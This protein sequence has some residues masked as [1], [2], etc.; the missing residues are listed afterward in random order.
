MGRLRDYTAKY[1]HIHTQKSHNLVMGSIEGREPSLEY[2]PY[3]TTTMGMAEHLNAQLAETVGEDTITALIDSRAKNY[4]DTP[5]LGEFRPPKDCGSDAGT[6]RWRSYSF[7]QLSQG[8]SAL[9]EKL[10][11]SS[12][13]RP[14][15]KHP[16]SLKCVALL[17]QTSVEL[18][19][20]WLAFMRLG[21]AVLLLAPQLTAEQIVH[22]CQSVGAKHLFVDRKLYET[23][24]I[25]AKIHKANSS[26]FLLKPH[27]LYPRKLF[28][29]LPEAQVIFSPPDWLTSQ[30]TAYIHH[31]SGTSS[32]KP[33][34]I[35][36]SHAGA[37]C[38]LPQRPVPPE[39]RK[40]QFTTTPLYH[41]GIADLMRGMNSN[42]LTWIVPASVP[43]TTTY[44]AT[45][46]RLAS[47]TTGDPSMIPRYFSC[48]PFILNIMSESNVGLEWLKKM[49]MVGVG[50][51]P[52]DQSIGD[53]LV[54]LG[55]K[56]VSR[57]GS[58]EA[59]Y[60]LNSF[61][62]FEKEHD[63][64]YL[65]Y[66]TEVAHKKLSFVERNTD[67]L[68]D[69][70]EL[71]KYEL[72]VGPTWPNLSKRNC[73]DGSF[74][75]SDLFTPADAELKKWKYT[76]RNDALIVL[77]SGKKYDPVPIETSIRRHPLIERYVSDVCIFV[78][79]GKNM[80]GIIIVHQVPADR[81]EPFKEK[82]KQVI[83][84]VNSKT[85]GNG[86][87]RHAWISEDLIIYD[88]A[89]NLPRNVKG[90]VIRNRTEEKY[91]AKIKE[92]YQQYENRFAPQ[93]HSSSPPDNRRFL[94]ENAPKDED[95]RS[96]RLQ[97]L[98]EFV[99]AVVRGI[100]LEWNTGVGDNEPHRNSGMKIEKT[101]DKVAKGL[102]NDTDLFSFGIDSVMGVE[103][104]GRLM[105]VLNLDSN[106][107]GT[108]IVFEQRTIR[109]L[110]K[111]ILSVVL[112]DVED[113]GEK[114]TDEE[115]M[116]GLVEKYREMPLLQNA[117]VSEQKRKEF[118][119]TEVVILTGATGTLGA[120]VLYQLL[121]SQTSARKKLIYCLVRASSDES[122]KSRV[123]ESLEKRGLD[124]TGLPGIGF[125]GLAVTL[126][127]PTLGLEQPIW[128]ELKCAM[129]HSAF[130]G[131]TIIHAAWPVNFVARVE[132]FEDQ[133]ATIN[134]LMGLLPSA[135][136]PHA[137]PCGPSNWDNPPT[138]FYTP[139]TKPKLIFISST[140][141][142]TNTPLRSPKHRTLMEK[143][144][145]DPI[146]SPE[147]GYSQSKWIAEKLCQAHR[148]QCM[149]VRVGQLCAD[150]I[151]GYWNEGEAWPLMF[152]AG[153]AIQALPRSIGDGEVVL[154]LPSDLAA[155]MVVEIARY[156]DG[157]LRGEYD[158]NDD[159]DD[160]DDDDDAEEFEDPVFHVLNPIPVHWSKIVH[161]TRA[162]GKDF[163]LVPP[164]TWVERI[165]KMLEEY[166]LSGER[167]AVRA[168]DRATPEGLRRWM[169]VHTMDGV[170][171]LV[172]M[173]QNMWG[174]PPADEK[175]KKARL[176]TPKPLPE[177]DVSNTA[178]VSQ[179]MREVADMEGGHGT[180]TASYTASRLGST[181]SDGDFAPTGQPVNKE[182][183]GKMLRSW[184]ERGIL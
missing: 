101:A 113:F 163:E 134:A 14:V 65:R 71:G 178:A 29:R 94:S 56:L 96:N 182:L 107:F 127:N 108:N 109:R 174:K 112:G 43:L 54:G 20:H 37:T 52:V 83:S 136:S 161:W 135:T 2:P 38:C 3:F 32:G 147:M 116:L 155:K 59:G 4:P 95:D 179:T 160:G 63:W 156:G 16:V 78:G 110:A 44:L 30:C 157:F 23:L 162:S 9:A 122:A 24:Q 114:E 69:E 76:G 145:K 115:I 150:T 177:F 62:D 18:V 50:G 123:V 82:V 7:L 132:S 137:E 31:T 53:K 28:L 159:G 80:S 26:S 105:K 48:V 152:A 45:M 36:Q 173:W 104:R 120:H 91:A 11:R 68:Q 106:R 46:L 119:D 92:K 166:E 153:M 1:L 22:L 141:S 84:H 131:G 15:E 58:T 133:F 19:Y 93:P 60:M 12:I 97:D 144:P 100:Y 81:M 168:V 8:T 21:Y 67:D 47:T 140:A 33:K 5:I 41:G 64:D 129:T 51:A 142:I 124:T 184:E 176:E 98:V 55:V 169:K 13:L 27:F 111:H 70:G 117:P 66:D 74:A 77:T 75:T 35:L 86:G 164:H 181:V 10:V 138:T 170:R 40:A 73:P 183:V 61:R 57:Y 72:I 172:G 90:L 118:E 88:N 151:H 34:P 167:D 149:V 49:D 87:S 128:G 17:A 79:S 103:I 180:A 99:G 143:Y 165:E 89:S 130:G 154:W 146:Q 6:W 102:R 25:S 171:G 85:S 148:S 121:K 125:K 158:H 126:D 139:R 39:E 175:D 42:N